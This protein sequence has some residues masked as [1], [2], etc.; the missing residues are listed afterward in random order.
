MTKNV[1]IFLLVL[2]FVLLLV[3]S[4]MGCD[5][6]DSS[7]HSDEVVVEAYLIA[8]Q[9][10]PQIRLTFT[11]DIKSRYIPSLQ[12]IRNANV[13]VRLMKA[14][15]SSESEFSYA[16]VADEPGVYRSE[17]AHRILP[18]R[19]YSFKATI[20]GRDPVTAQTI[21][22]GTFEIK[23]LNAETI[24]YQAES[25][26]EVNITP[27]FY[28]GRQN[29]LVFSLESLAPDVRDLTPF[30][31]DIIYGI[32]GNEE[33]N[34]DSLD[35][36]KLDPFLTNASPPI[37]EGN[38]DINPDGTMTVRLPWFFVAFYGQNRVFTSAIDDGLYDFMRF[39]HVQAGGSTLSP[40]EIPNILDHIDGGRGVF[41]SM[42]R[43]SA[44][45]LITR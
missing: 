12:A 36:S 14:D 29:I 28:P 34:P 31:L 18:Q 19:T 4:F 45:V 11:A 15:G 43:V 26:F 8:E 32:R 1:F 44:D 41:G 39:Q 22:P 30:Y 7:R 37:N 27:S 9:Q 10:I 16:H 17:Q 25:Q 5:T 2:P 40:G 23:G 33:Y 35:A 20:P 24:T 3:A 13:V 21:V 6:T 42:A 38:Y